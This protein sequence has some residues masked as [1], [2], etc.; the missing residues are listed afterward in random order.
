MIG[1]CYMCSKPN[2][3]IKQSHGGL[4]CYDCRHQ[5][6]GFQSWRRVL[7]NNELG[8]VCIKI[9]PK[10]RRRTLAKYVRTISKREYSRLMVRDIMGYMN[11]SKG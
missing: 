6:W 3:P 4:I 7:I 8:M 11:T 5:T 1:E 2:Y 9:K 10:I